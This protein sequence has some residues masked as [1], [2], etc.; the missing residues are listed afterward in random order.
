MTIGNINEN[1]VDVPWSIKKKSPTLQIPKT[2]PSWHV[3]NRNFLLYSP[4][5]W[6]KVD[7]SSYFLLPDLHFSDCLITNF[8]LNTEVWLNNSVLMHKL[9]KQM[10]L[11]LHFPL[12]SLFLL[13][14][15]IK[16]HLL[17]TY[18]QCVVQHP[19]LS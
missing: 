2:H 19:I 16:Y 7:L 6:L 11:G 4:R 18:T 15:D 8:T 17:N 9:R 1:H 14:I 5:K 12:L 13:L 3:W 10:Y